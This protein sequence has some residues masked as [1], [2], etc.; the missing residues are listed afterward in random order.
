[1]SDYKGTRTPTSTP[2][3]AFAARISRTL[4]KGGVPTSQ[5]SAPRNRE[6][7]RV[8]QGG[9]D[10]YAAVEADFDTDATARRMADA[11]EEV[12]HDAGYRTLR[13]GNGMITV[14]RDGDAA[15]SRDERHLRG[16]TVDGAWAYP[17]IRSAKRSAQVT[18]SSHQFRPIELN[19]VSNHD[20]APVATVGLSPEAAIKLAE[21]LYHAATGRHLPKN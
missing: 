3:S 19:L 7:V 4:R 2:R 17:L 5:G 13:Y 18:K 8:G 9:D 12:L 6:G 1:M 10:S 16:E 15:D 11:A 14:Y 20:D 21:Q